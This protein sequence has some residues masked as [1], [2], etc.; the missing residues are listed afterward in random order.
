MLLFYGFVFRPLYIEHILI[1]ITMRT[2]LVI[3]SFNQKGES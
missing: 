1:I 3:M 2:T